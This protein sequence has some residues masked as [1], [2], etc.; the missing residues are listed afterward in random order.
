M[1]TFFNIQYEFD[2]TEVHNAISKRLQQ[3]GSD[4]I[5]VADGVVLDN[6]TRHKKYLSVINGGMF[7]ICD[8]S[9][10]PLYLKWIYGIQR[11]QYY[12]YQIFLDIV[13]SR[14]YRMFF[15]GSHTTVIEGLRKELPKI[16]PDITGMTFAEL[17]FCSVDEFDYPSI[18][19]AIEQ[20]GAEIIWV[21]LGAPKQEIF[22]S[23]LKPHLS[24]G[25]IIAVGAVFK[26][27]SGTDT[28][29]APEWM[30]R[31]HLEFV[32]RLCS[33]PRKQF[34]RVTSLLIT[35]PTILLTELNHKRQNKTH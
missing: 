14:K 4:Y 27:C 22:M 29:R 31:N 26:F 33:E 30:I 3:P 5:C 35:L 10:V 17:P 28:R 24:H 21:S 1:E 20:D 12:G 11:Y 8:S 25:I 16:N 6:A 2:P 7:C 23:R 19:K 13:Q 15:I 18:A 9:Y 32:Y 34:R